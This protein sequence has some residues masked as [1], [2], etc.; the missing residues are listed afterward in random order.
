MAK[1]KEIAVD[2]TFIFF[3]WENHIKWYKWEKCLIRRDLTNRESMINAMRKNNLDKPRKIDNHIIYSVYRTYHVG[4][5]T[6]VSKRRQKKKTTKI[7]EDKIKLIHQYICTIKNSNDH[8]C[9]KSKHF[10]FDRLITT[11][12]WMGE[13][14]R[15]KHVYSDW[16]LVCQWCGQCLLLA[17][18]HSI[19]AEGCLA[20]SARDAAMVP[21][22]TSFQM[23]RSRPPRLAT[24]AQPTRL[25][26]A[27]I[28]DW[29]RIEC[30]N[31]NYSATEMTT[32]H[33]LARYLS[34]WIQK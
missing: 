8:F 23:C 2:F 20:W 12:M 25:A 5:N 7:W 32:K 34:N 1:K 21:Y 16:R 24:H 19:Y 18:L 11:W 3:L 9:E 10:E 13:S 17:A 33:A 31:L 26:E 29:N 27:W 6:Y 4:R 22:S 28:I 14:H 15:W 30:L